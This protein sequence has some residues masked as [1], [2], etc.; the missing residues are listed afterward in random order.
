MLRFLYHLFFDKIEL[1]RAFIA[2]NLHR[3]WY[4]LIAFPFPLPRGLAWATR[5]ELLLGAF[6]FVGSGCFW[7]FLTWMVL[8]VLMALY[9]R[10]LYGFDIPFLI[11]TAMCMGFAFIALATTLYLLIAMVFRQQRG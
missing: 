11:L 8:L 4:R 3:R 6:R 1:W 9:K 2:C 10:Q 7:L 5:R